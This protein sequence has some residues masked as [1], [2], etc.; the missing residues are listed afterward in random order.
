MDAWPLPVTRFL[1]KKMEVKVW[2]DDDSIAIQWGLGNVV[3]RAR[4]DIEDLSLSRGGI[5]DVLSTGDRSDE[6][7]T[8]HNTYAELDAGC[9]F[10]YT[11][12]EG[13]EE[14]IK[15]QDELSGLGIGVSEFMI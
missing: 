14:L 12:F 1:E 6:A 15:F 11:C 4:W 8:G 2:F 7:A 10:Y 13:V 9:V 3:D 5:V